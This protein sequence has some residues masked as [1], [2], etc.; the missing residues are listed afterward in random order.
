LDYI[1]SRFH[2]AVESL[3]R[4]LKSSSRFRAPRN[5]AFEVRKLRRGSNGYLEL[6]QYADTSVTFWRYPVARPQSFDVLLGQGYP[7][8]DLRQDF[9]LH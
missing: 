9:G 6:A 7:L 8:S 3:F 2:L 1:V 5:Q 4:V